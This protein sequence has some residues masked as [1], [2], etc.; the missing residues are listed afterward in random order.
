[1]QKESLKPEQNLESLLRETKKQEASQW[2][3]NPQ[4]EGWRRELVNLLTRTEKKLGGALDGQA[5]ALIIDAAEESTKQMRVARARAAGEHIKELPAGKAKEISAVMNGSFQMNGRTAKQIDAVTDE[6]RARVAIAREGSG[7]G[8]GTRVT[9]VGEEMKGAAR[10][11]VS[12][13]EKFRQGYHGTN[14]TALIGEARHKEMELKKVILRIDYH[15]AGKEDF[16]KIIRTGRELLEKHRERAAM[17]GATKTDR[18]ESERF[19]KEFKAGLLS[20]SESLYQ[21]QMKSIDKGVREWLE[22][23][24]AVSKQAKISASP[25]I[26]ASLHTLLKEVENYRPEGSSLMGV[27]KQA[28]DHLMK[29]VVKTVGSNQPSGHQLVDYTKRSLLQQVYRYTDTTLRQMKMDYR[30]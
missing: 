10:Q 28:M 29:Q 24:R 23:Y 9:R 12:E 2:K 4:E 30:R 13:M 7:G 16:R 1:M 18:Q 8:G 25:Q 11:I 19:E 27:K 21:K 22:K 26:K 15:Q 3:Q 20:L 17:Q 14:S 6:L 5:R